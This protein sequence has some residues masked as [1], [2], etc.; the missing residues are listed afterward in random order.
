LLFGCSLF[1][2]LRALV[3]IQNNVPTN[4]LLA[5]VFNLRF[6]VNWAGVDIVRVDNGSGDGLDRLQGDEATQKSL[7]SLVQN[8]RRDAFAT[9]ARLRE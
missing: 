1:F 3:W 7:L 5:G 4:L 2:L 6:G 9:S 8:R